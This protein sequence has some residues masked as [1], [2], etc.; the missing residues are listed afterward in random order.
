V[1]PGAAEVRGTLVALGLAGAVLATLVLMRPLTP[2]GLASRPSPARSYDEGL[3]LARAL[4]G[5]EDERIQPACRSA[6]RVHGR[7][8]PRVIVFFHGLTNCPAQFDSLAGLCFAGGANVYVPR[9]PRHGEADR[10]TEALAG[11]DARE[12][13][14]FTDRAVDAAAGLGDTVVVAGLSVGATMAAWAAQERADVDHAVV[15]APLLAPP[16]V[17]TAPARLLTR[18][19][20]RLPNRFLWWD[21]ERRADLPGPPH[22][23]PR[24]ATRAVAASLFLGAAV[25]QAARTRAPGAGTIA[26]LTLEHDPAVSNAAVRTL[27]RAWRG[28]SD[29]KIVAYEF[30]A[31]LGLNHDMIDPLQV[32]ANPRASY[33][34]I[35]RFIAPPGP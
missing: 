15:I 7:R 28:R 5:E 23:Y 29:G 8:T 2:A 13:R 10:L 1:K 32:G 35:L 17:S 11:S 14:A 33:P 34:V 27:E 30:P 31:S 22:V 18:A 16:R 19:I 9:L 3:A 6:L 24:Y 21:A 12:L 20:G 4:A 25:E 26:L